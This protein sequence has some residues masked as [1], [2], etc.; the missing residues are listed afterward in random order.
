M[1]RHRDFRGHKLQAVER[2]VPGFFETNYPDTGHADSPYQRRYLLCAGESPVECA[3]LHAEMLL[4]HE[5]N[6]SLTE[7]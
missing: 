1:A 2:G 3:L 5:T 4:L 7:S 6:G